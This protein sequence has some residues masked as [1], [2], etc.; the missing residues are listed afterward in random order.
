M[1]SQNQDN[2]LSIE[3]GLSALSLHPFG[4]N[5]ECMGEWCLHRED[6]TK[7]Y[8]SLPYGKLLTNAELQ[9]DIAQSFD[10]LK[11]QSESHSWEAHSQRKPIC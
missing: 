9:E 1:F 7:K 2:P 3:K 8:K 10:R 6:P 5:A 4:N 11:K